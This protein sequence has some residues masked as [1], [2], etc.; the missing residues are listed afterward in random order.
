MATPT[1]EMA[2]LP[3]KGTHTLAEY[4][5]WCDRPENVDRMFE[6]IDGEIIEKEVGSYVPSWVAGQI[7]LAIGIYL[8]QNPI[9]RLTGADGTYEMSDKNALIPDL[10]FTLKVRL[11]EHPIR[12][13]TIPPDLTVEVKSPSDRYRALRRKAERYLE[14]GTKMVWLVFPE[15]QLIEVYTTDA[16]VE[17]IDSNG[18][19]T[20]GDLLPG[21][22][23]SVRDIFAW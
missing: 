23:L 18:I 5:E 19:V 1:V 9:G 22:T 17:T 10:A 6:L 8:R 3:E 21:F 20:G 12:S 11:P 2:K 14:L 4:R 16:D 15:K 7:F 13:A